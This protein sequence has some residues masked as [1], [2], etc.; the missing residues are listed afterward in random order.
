[1]NHTRTAELE[2]AGL[3]DPAAFGV[4]NRAG[5]VHLEARLGEPE[6]VRPDPHPSLGTEKLLNEVV[7]GALQ[8]GDGNVFINQQPVELVEHRHVR[9][10][11][12]PPVALGDIN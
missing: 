2:P 12:L 7:K 3:T 8:L 10:V 6:V 11:N 4:T 5:D 9:R 1:M